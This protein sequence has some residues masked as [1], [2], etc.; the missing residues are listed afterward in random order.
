MQVLNSKTETIVGQLSQPHDVTET[1][2][3]E[4]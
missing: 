3:G 1:G 4:W 2:S